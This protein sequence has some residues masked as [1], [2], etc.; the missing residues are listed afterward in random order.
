M[1]IVDVLAFLLMLSNMELGQVSK[2]I[3]SAIR[4]LLISKGVGLFDGAFIG[5]TTCD[6]RRPSRLRLALAAKS[7]EI[8]VRTNRPC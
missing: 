2:T 5:D 3:M 8:A 7:E 6:D 1:D 4:R